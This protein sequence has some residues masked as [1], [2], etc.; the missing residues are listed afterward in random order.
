MNKSR[1]AAVGLALAL[2]CATAWAQGPSGDQGTPIAKD[3]PQTRSVVGQVM[4]QGSQPLQNAIVHLKNTKTLAVSTFI[5]REDGKYR[6]TALVPNVDY[7]IFA[8]QNG[9]K[10]STKTLSAF[11]SR[12]TVTVN[13]HIETGK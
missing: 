11:E 12:S 7:E 8:E 10:S 13:L 5:T 1:M 3:E 9:K 4:D 2:A 6:F